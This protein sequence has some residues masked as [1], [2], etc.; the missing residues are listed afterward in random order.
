MKLKTAAAI[1]NWDDDDDDDADNYEEVTKAKIFDQS[2]WSTFYSRVYK[3]KIDGTFWEII[4]SRG[5][6]E[7]QDNGPEDI[8]VNQVEPYEKTIIEY[9]RVKG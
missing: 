1:L 7:Q 4:W 5:S 8:G 2:R 3:N 9:R 6:T